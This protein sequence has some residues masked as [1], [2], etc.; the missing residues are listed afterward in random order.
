MAS[1]IS[2]LLNVMMPTF[3]CQMMKER[4]FWVQNGRVFHFLALFLSFDVDF[5]DVSQKEWS[6]DVV[7]EMFHR[8]NDLQT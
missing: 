7:L 8:K 6:S 5:I 4:Q 2:V 1:Q 3:G